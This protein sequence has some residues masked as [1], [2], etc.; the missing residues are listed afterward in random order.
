MRYLLDTMVVSEPARPRPE[1]RVVQWLEVQPV[2]DLAISTITI[3]EIRKG[4]DLMPD[5]PR[6]MELTQWMSN[7]LPALFRDRVIG[8]DIAVAT[9]WGRLAARC[10]KIG[11]PVQVIDGLL[12]ASALVHGMTLV[13]RNTGHCA[14]LGAPVL[15][16]WTGESFEPELPGR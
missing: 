7:S 16:P 14:G 3:G 9:E 8:V 11:R 2:G 12:V 4:V 6:R 13:T 5:G 10:Q 1:P 15:N